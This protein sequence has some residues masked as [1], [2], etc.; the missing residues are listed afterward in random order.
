MGKEDRLGYRVEPLAALFWA[1]GIVLYSQ[2]LILSAGPAS[3][4]RR[5]T[6]SIS[7][8]HIAGAIL[9][10]DGLALHPYPI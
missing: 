4:H 6:Q 7:Y 1:L 5:R 9:N 2:H 10:E 8:G 3:L